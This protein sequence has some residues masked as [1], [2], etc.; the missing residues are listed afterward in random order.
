MR[1]AMQDDVVRG[2]ACPVGKAEGAPSVSR[3]S[4]SQ[5]ELVPEVGGDLSVA[6]YPP[7][8]PPQQQQ[9]RQ[10]P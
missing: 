1:P 9:R 2:H 10:Q 5:W 6:S 7:T 8:P 4:I 3:S